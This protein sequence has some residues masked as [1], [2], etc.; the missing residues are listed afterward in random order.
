LDPAR[1]IEKMGRYPP[2]SAQTPSGARAAGHSPAMVAYSSNRQSQQPE[3]MQLQ[4][5][6][7][8]TDFLELAQSCA[9]NQPSAH[10]L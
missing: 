2:A 5:R 6:H 7:S 1:R 9:P 3:A 4:Q 10:H 8:A